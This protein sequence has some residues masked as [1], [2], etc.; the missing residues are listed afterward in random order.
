MT[1]RRAEIRSQSWSGATTAQRCSWHWKTLTRFS[2]LRQ[3]PSC[4]DRP[5]YGGARK[6]MRRYVGRVAEATTP[7]SVVHREPSLT[8]EDFMERAIDLAV[9]LH[10]LQPGRAVGSRDR[11][12]RPSW[13]DAT[14]SPRPT[15]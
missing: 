3:H 5:A 12:Q 15:M 7:T 13:E 6:K 10:A 11:A 14:R 1:A 4:H 8:N 2:S 9:E